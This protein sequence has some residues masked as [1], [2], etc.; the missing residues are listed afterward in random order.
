[1]RKRKC[2]VTGHVEKEKLAFATVDD[3]QIKIKRI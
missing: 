1:M 2:P 3:A